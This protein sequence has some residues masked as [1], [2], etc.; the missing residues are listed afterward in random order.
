MTGYM[1]RAVAAGG[2]VAFTARP[3]PKTEHEEQ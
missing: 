2:V 3:A 1:R